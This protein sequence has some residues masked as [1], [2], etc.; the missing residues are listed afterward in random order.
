IGMVLLIN[1]GRGWSLLG[2]RNAIVDIL[3]D[4]RP[5]RDWSTY[6][7]NLDRESELKAAKSKAERLAKRIPDTKPT[8]PL[9][10]YAGEYRNG[11]Y[12]PVKVSLVDGALALEWVRIKAPLTHYHYDVFDAAE[13][14]HALEETV[15]FA[16]DDEKK[17]KSLT[18][19]G[20][21]FTKN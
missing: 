20:E 8:R 15:T 12:G 11:A 19:F 18:F 13:E 3:L 1:A 7:L 17:V 5:S 6:Y 4:G 9:A 2:M 14:E 10:E 16:L 21:T